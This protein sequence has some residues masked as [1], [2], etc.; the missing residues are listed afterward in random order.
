VD[1][2]NTE[3]NESNNEKTFDF[4]VNPEPRPD[5]VIQRMTISPENPTTADEITLT[6]VVKNVGNEGSGS[7]Q[8]EIKA[9][10]EGRSPRYLVPVLAPNRTHTARRTLTLPV[11]QTY[12]STATIDVDSRN[13]E[14]D[15]R[16]NQEILDFTVRSGG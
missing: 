16:N 13:T 12:R 14:S 10:G 7:C 5:L 8:L 11:A 9:G 6:V 15:E 2:R 1:D 4:T 3:S